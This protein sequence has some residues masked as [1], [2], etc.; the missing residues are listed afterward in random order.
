[1]RQKYGLFP[2]KIDPIFLLENAS[3]MTETNFTL[4]QKK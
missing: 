4:G 3:I 2:E 1:M